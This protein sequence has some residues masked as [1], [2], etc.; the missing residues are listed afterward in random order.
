MV[1]NVS[2]VADLSISTRNFKFYCISCPFS[3]LAGHNVIARDVYK[4][5]SYERL[6]LG[7][8]YKH[9]YTQ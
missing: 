1:M 5:V 3:K 6:I 8:W 7:A 9:K 4:F 2:H